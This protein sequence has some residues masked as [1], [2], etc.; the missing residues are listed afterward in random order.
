MPKTLL[1]SSAKLGQSQQ[2]C[3]EARGG[4]RCSAGTPMQLHAATAPRSA[5][6]RLDAELRSSMA[7]A[8][9]GYGHLQNRF[10]LDPNL[11]M[12]VGVQNPRVLYMCSRII[13]FGSAAVE[14]LDANTTLRW[15]VEAYRYLL[16]TGFPLPCFACTL[17]L[18]LGSLQTLF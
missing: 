11:V 14:F 5:A 18:P 6:A 4:Q 10:C 3:L 2:R 17:P 9:A 7:T 16:S 13:P 8:Q 12:P 15:K 1:P